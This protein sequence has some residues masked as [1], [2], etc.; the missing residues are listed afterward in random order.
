MGPEALDELLS[1]GPRLKIADAVSVRPR[2][3]GEL[4]DLT[5][6]SVQGVLRH[7]KRLAEL[8][9]IEERT[10]SP[11]TPKA[12]R[13]YASKEFRVGDFSA[14]GL[15]VVKKTRRLRGGG[16]R[17]PPERDLEEA[18]ADLLVRKRRVRDEV[19]RLG[20]M[21]DGLVEDE[22]SLEAALDEV[23]GDGLRRLILDVLLT[24][25]TVGEGEKA[26][27]RYYGIFDRRSIE[28]ALAKV[29]RSAGR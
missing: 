9:V 23:G 3:L 29:K 8:G 7:L 16:Q 28:G 4:A 27:S 12:R 11:S 6:I 14:P 24:E 18:A 22:E 19:R 5:G 2:T 21:I 26:L 17:H 13:V 15:T 25:E 20:R 10:L 1:S